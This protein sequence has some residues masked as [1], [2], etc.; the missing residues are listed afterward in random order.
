MSAD[1]MRKFVKEKKE[2]KGMK[3]EA[4]K[5]A[6]RKMREFKNKGSLQTIESLNLEE[7]Q[8]EQLD[9]RIRLSNS[10][11]PTSERNVSPVLLSELKNDLESSSST[12]EENNNSQQQRNSL[13]L[14]DLEDEL[15]DNFHTSS[16]D[17]DDECSIGLEDI[18]LKT[19]PRDRFSRRDTGQFDIKVPDQFQDDIS[20]MGTTVTHPNKTKSKQVI[21]VPNQILDVHVPDQFQDDISAM[22]TT[23]VTCANKTKPVIQV[24]NKIRDDIS[25]LAFDWTTSSS[26]LKHHWANSN[27]GRQMLI[28]Q[29]SKQR[30][31]SELFNRTSLPNEQRELEGIKKIKHR[32]TIEHPMSA[33]KNKSKGGRNVRSSTLLP[34]D[35]V[36]D[37]SWF[38]SRG[39]MSR[40][41]MRVLKKEMRKSKSKPKPKPKPLIELDDLSV[42]SDIS[43][44]DL[45]DRRVS[46]DNRDFDAS[47]YSIDDEEK[48]IDDNNIAAD[49][50]TR[51]I[52]AYQ[53]SRARVSV[54]D[55]SD[56]LS[57][58]VEIKKIQGMIDVPQKFIDDVS[59]LEFDW[60]TS[61]RSLKDHWAKNGGG[62]IS[63]DASSICSDSEKEVAQPSGDNLSEQ[64]WGCDEGDSADLKAI[65]SLCI[66]PSLNRV[67]SG[68]G[69]QAQHRG[70][71]LRRKN[72]PISS[73]SSSNKRVSF[74]SGLDAAVEGGTERECVASSVDDSMDRNDLMSRPTSC[75]PT[76]PLPFEHEVIEQQSS[77]AETDVTEVKY[78]QVEKRVSIAKSE[79]SELT[80]QNNSSCEHPWILSEVDVLSNTD[81]KDTKALS[82]CTEEERNQAFA[83][84]IQSMLKLEREKRK[85][86]LSPVEV[87]ILQKM[88][89]RLS[90]QEGETDDSTDTASI[91]EANAC[92][93][94]EPVD[95]LAESFNSSET[96]K[97]KNMS[98]SHAEMLAKVARDMSASLERSRAYR[99]KKEPNHSRIGQI[100]SYSH[101]TAPSKDMTTINIV[102]P[103]PQIVKQHL[104]V[105]LTAKVAS[106]AGEEMT[107][108]DMNKGSNG[109]SGDDITVNEFTTNTKVTL[110]DLS[111]N[112]NDSMI[113]APTNEPKSNRRSSITDASMICLHSAFTTKS[114]DNLNS[115]QQQPLQQQLEVPTSPP[116]PKK[117]VSF[118]SYEDILTMG[119]NNL[120]V[121]MLVN[122]YG[123]LREMSLLG[124]AS[125][126]LRDI[127]VNSHQRNSRMKEL[128][129]LNL[130]KPEDENKGYLETT[131]TAG[132]I[133]RAAIDE[134]E[135][136]ES[137][138][139]I[140]NGA[141][142][143]V[144]K[145]CMEYDATMV[146]DFKAWV[147]ESLT[148]NFDGH[149]FEEGSVMRDLVDSGLE[150]VWISDRHPSDVNY[151]ICVNRIA[152]RVTVVFRG[153]EGV[154]RI[155]KDSQMMEHENPLAEEVENTEVIK[156]RAAVS[157][158]ILTPRL[159]TK[160]SIVEE[161]HDRVNKIREE[162]TGRDACHLTICGHSLGGGLA[163]VTGFYLACNNNLKLASPIQIVT[164]ASPR[165][166]GNEFQRS[167]QHLEDSGRILYARFT[168][169]NDMISLRP[170]W[171][172]SG[173]WKFEDWY[174]VSNSGFSFEIFVLAVLNIVRL[175]SLVKARRDARLLRHTQCAGV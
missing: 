108:H 141:L 8:P 25:S 63:G 85:S 160:K 29:S 57:Q 86:G 40:N 67:T 127:D 93:E 19:Q 47:H 43:G 166:G 142:C 10:P 137:T 6:M 12:M 150:V 80:F 78:I 156:L 38:A 4:K 120:S 62:G 88:V 71:I 104:P 167:F 123:R 68:M 72:S 101:D 22:G 128:K 130:L 39:L 135:M 147:A 97:M 109:S 168:N 114:E 18:G 171:A 165:V 77:P 144:K 140:E 102:Q 124:H 121:T 161:I 148:K 70:S 83:D 111:H 99:S 146:S 117:S 94:G 170:F 1:S 133:V 21:Q 106:P 172:I 116:V 107:S 45:N 59:A 115:G 9:C 125:V 49:S 56:E 46:Q 132:Y 159:D 74:N 136:F 175:K 100:K 153:D 158:N 75:Y 24:P 155:V 92:L 152:S 126:R 162:L 98:Q 113:P 58:D 17:H 52:L 76:D 15:N 112:N 110:H 30:S 61:S 13:K 82:E 64:A 54:S 81:E 5:I 134:Y 163:T 151:C 44:L 65:E 55:H 89:K 20:A 157:K 119:I 73:T 96:P 174:K 28:A 149:C 41:S 53:K 3:K 32:R 173:S 16:D 11:Q 84:M 105:K 169:L 33:L 131:M 90:S 48:K 129:R 164:F 37:A 31:K 87:N 2:E 26:K 60:K 143:Q 91:E 35:A 95:V 138:S 23:T 103:A 50:S 139:C 69:S 34:N 79:I 154:L 7:S 42:S 27:S 145:A 66:T 36:Q 118:E 122:I 14:T 51:P